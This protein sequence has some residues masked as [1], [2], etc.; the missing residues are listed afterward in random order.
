MKTAVAVGLTALVACAAVAQT[1]PGLRK[2]EKGKGWGWC[3]GPEDEV[4]ALNEQTDAS[5]LAALRLATSGKVYDLGV[6]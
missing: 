5:R 3:W 4:G 2:W 1:A 6:D